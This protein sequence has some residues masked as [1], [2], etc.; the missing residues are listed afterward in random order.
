MAVQVRSLLKDSFGEFRIQ[1]TSKW[2]RAFIDR[3]AVVDTKAALVVREPRRITPLYAVPVSDIA[4]VLVPASRAAAKD[5]G[6]PVLDPSVPFS[7]HTTP[8]VAYSIEGR[9][10]GAR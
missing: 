10:Q 7:V 8:G 2:V 5:D 4:G 6:R 1:S 3:N 9:G